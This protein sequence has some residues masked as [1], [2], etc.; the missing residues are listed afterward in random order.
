MRHIAQGGPQQRDSAALDEHGAASE[1]TPAEQLG[2]ALCGQG[3]SNAAMVGA[4]GFEPAT[5][6]L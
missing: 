2:L 5:S 4:A 3:S 6:R 1:Q